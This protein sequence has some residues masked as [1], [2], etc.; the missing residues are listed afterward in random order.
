[1]IDQP[2]GAADDPA[3]DA[4]PGAG[5][6][7]EGHVDVEAGL[8][9]GRVEA[10]RVHAAQ[11]DAG[12]CDRQRREGR[13]DRPRPAVDAGTAGAGVEGE[14]GEVAGRPRRDGVGLT[15]LVGGEDGPGGER[16]GLAA[17]EGQPAGELAEGRADA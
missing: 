1:M 12:R 8:G 3:G 2:D 13:G 15:G 16:K 11:L 5:A 17:V 14:A 4:L 10:L 6:G 7:L 9:R